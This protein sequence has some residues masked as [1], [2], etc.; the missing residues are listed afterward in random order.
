MCQKCSNRQV[1]HTI[2]SHVS[3]LKGSKASVKAEI[4]LFLPCIQRDLRVYENV[5]S[6]PY[7]LGQLPS[8]FIEGVQSA[9]TS[10]ADKCVHYY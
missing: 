8:N 2:F 10:S 7:N 4:L 1:F 9:K 5:T 6:Y 3:C